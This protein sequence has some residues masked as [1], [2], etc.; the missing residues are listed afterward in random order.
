[1]VRIHLA[2]TVATLGAFEQVR[3]GL[4]VEIVDIDGPF[5]GYIEF[6]IFRTRDDAEVIFEFDTSACPSVCSYRRPHYP[7]ALLAS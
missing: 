2:E 5:I 3:E 6:G 1:M 4:R 7:I